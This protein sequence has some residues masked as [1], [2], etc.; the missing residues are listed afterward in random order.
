M[1]LNPNIPNDEYE[2]RMAKKEKSKKKVVNKVAVG[3]GVAALVTAAI[4]FVILGGGPKG[5]NTPY[6]SPNASNTTTNEIDESSAVDPGDADIS[7]IG[8]DE[9][10]PLCSDQAIKDLI[11]F[12]DQEYQNL[13]FLVDT[14]EEKGY[15]TSC[16]TDEEHHWKQ[17]EFDSNYN[18]FKETYLDS[19]SAYANANNSERIII[20]KKIYNTHTANVI[21]QERVELMCCYW[22]KLGWTS[23]QFLA[24]CSEVEAK[25]LQVIADYDA[26]DSGE[27]ST[28][29]TEK[30]FE[31]VYTD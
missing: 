5:Y 4:V 23:D 1:S 25:R 30:D 27:Y 31:K 29:D 28:S 14:N 13:K 20:I 10:N 26:L 15:I 17:K 12:T 18:S 22:K 8:V 11:A 3:T 7:D 6:T 21:N 9:D 24:K 16:D 19:D 2:S